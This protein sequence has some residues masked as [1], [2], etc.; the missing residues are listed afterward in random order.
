MLGGTPTFVLGRGGHAIVVS[1]GPGHTRS[2]YRTG[3]VTGD[4]ADEW[5]AN[6]SEHRG[7]WWDHW[8]HWIEEHSPDKRLRPPR[9]RSDSYRP[10]GDAPGDYV[11]RVIA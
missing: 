4:D 9:L 8:N 10:L 1:R 7:S 3:T 11:R 2:S 6:S 5:L